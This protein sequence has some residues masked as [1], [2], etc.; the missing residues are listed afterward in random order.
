MLPHSRFAGAA[1]QR[2]VA[3]LAEE[4]GVKQKRAPSRPIFC[5]VVSIDAGRRKLAQKVIQRN[6]RIMRRI[7]EAKAAVG[8]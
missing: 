4:W 1:T 6:R 2:G 7:A 3:E 5:E 8:Q